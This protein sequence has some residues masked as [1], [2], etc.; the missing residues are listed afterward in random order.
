M[1]SKGLWICLSV[2]LVLGLL[3]GGFGCKAPATPTPTPTPA[4]ASP[5]PSP[6]TSAAPAPASPKP[7]PATPTPAPA[8]PEKVITIRFT[9][10]GP[11]TEDSVMHIYCV[12]V[13][14]LC[15]KYFPGRVK[16]EEYPAG[17]LYGLIPGFNAL[18]SGAVEMTYANDGQIS[19]II[20]NIE[21]VKVP[22]LIKSPAHAQDFWLTYAEKYS[23]K[24]L[25]QK[26]NAGIM[27]MCPIDPISFWF[28]KPFSS[29]ADIKG[30]KMATS[31]SPMTKA[32][33][34]ELKLAL[35]DIPIAD[36]LPALQTG[37]ADGVAET[38][39]TSMIRY[40]LHLQSKYYFDAKLS[41]HW[42]QHLAFYNRPWF[43]SLPKDVA[44]KLHDVIW[45]EATNAAYA[46]QT[47]LA[48]QAVKT[49]KEA[50]CVASDLG[51]K[52]TPVLMNEI[53][54]KLGKQF[55]GIVDEDAIKLINEL[56]KKYEPGQSFEL[57]K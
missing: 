50:G 13:K 15:E 16:F 12:K 55:I 24:Y 30:R 29:L 54:P 19:G 7:S 2:L 46:L 41:A 14:E 38:S 52:D 51:A 45:P 44:A 1:K 9:H 56:G 33:C 36:R 8:T 42:A 39:M 28:K 34:E 47:R 11:A 18:I 17:Q 31:I 40:S 27:A 35:V 10:T 6:A 32:I 3:V 57:K 48:A 21:I 43:E 37:V 4:P 25:Y 26:Y 5:K 53:W 20:P 23:E 22:G 49:L